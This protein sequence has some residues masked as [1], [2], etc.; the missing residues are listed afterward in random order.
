[1][2]ELEEDKTKPESLWAIVE[3][4]G[5]QRIA[6]RLSEHNF[7]GQAFVRVDVP[8]I[9]QE[10]KPDIPPVTKLF[11]NGAIYAINFVDETSARLTAATLRVQPVNTWDLRE[12]L[13]AMGEA[14]VRRLGFQPVADA[15]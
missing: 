9:P 7:G 13:G 15:P 3:L 2:F 5:H 1:M 4:F 12:A 10:G 11:G 8:A 6:G 14:G